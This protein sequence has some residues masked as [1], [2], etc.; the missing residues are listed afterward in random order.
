LALQIQAGFIN[1]FSHVYLHVKHVKILCL[2]PVD[3]HTLS[4]WHVAQCLTLLSLHS[5]LQVY[6][7]EHASNVLAVKLF[8]VGS[9]MDHGHAA[10]GHAPG[11]PG[12]GGAA[13]LGGMFGAGS[14][15]GSSGNVV[16][17]TELE[18]VLSL[19][20]RLC[21]VSHPHVLQHVAVYPHV[22]EVRCMI[23]CLRF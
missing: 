13:G 12:G 6:T 22:Y 10:G 5:A 23:V 11:G 20:Y 16:R 17:E 19:Q 1:C 4:L 15:S 8:R 14:G 2:L 3:L 18:A 9:S 21:S 7:A